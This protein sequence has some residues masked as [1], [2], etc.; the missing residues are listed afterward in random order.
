MHRAATPR[1]TRQPTLQWEKRAWS[2]GKLL[3]A[4]VD[5]VG[6]GAWAGPIVAAA[7]IV[8]HDPRE[9]ARMTRALNRAGAHVRDSKLLSPR[10]RQTALDVVNGLGVPVAVVELGPAEID[11]MGLAVANRTVL[12]EA[13]QRLSSQPDH[14][15]VDAY[16]LDDLDCPHDSVIRGDSCCVSI[17]LASIVAKLHRD[18]IME[19]LGYDYPEYGFGQHKGYGTELHQCAI[20]DHGI[21]V[22]HRRSFAPIAGLIRDGNAVGR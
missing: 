7:V 14:V 21:T 4:G 19:R 15:L 22:H 6:R 9:R 2:D 3:V 10:Q 8:P 11:A 5:E 18:A 16:R 12:R 20:A 13:V 1:R 17:A